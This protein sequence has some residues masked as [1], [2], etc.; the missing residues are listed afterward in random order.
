MIT[1]F[2]AELASAHSSLAIC[3]GLFANELDECQDISSMANVLITS[4]T[5]VNTIATVSR[6]SKM[7]HTY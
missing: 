5:L 2:T 1:Q 7:F 3:S 6:G 4:M